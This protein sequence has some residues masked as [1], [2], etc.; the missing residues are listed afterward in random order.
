MKKVLM[1]HGFNGEPNG[2][3]RPWLMGKLAIDDI[4]ACSLPM[5][6][7]S[8]PKKDE[9]V[10]MISDSVG[11]PNE[12]IFLIG[13]S[14]GVPSALRYLESL[15]EGK[16]IGGAVL[17]SGIIEVIPEKEK[18]SKINHFFE[19]PFDFDHIKNVCPN[20]IVIHG[21]D[22]PAVPFTQAQKLSRELNCE[23]IP[24]KNG[25]HLNGSSGWYELPEAYDAL[26]KMIN[27]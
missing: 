15:P 9:W 26:I 7:P 3:W 13:H 21:E 17:V 19:N 6:T 25:G 24:V 16:R 4:W 22:D 5:P 2:G 12:E 27:K 1:V 18:Y 10:N 20:I 11:E 23:L 8:D 14:L